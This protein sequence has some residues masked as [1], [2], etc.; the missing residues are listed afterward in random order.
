V[1]L[2]AIEE[3]FDDAIPSRSKLLNDLAFLVSSNRLVEDQ[4]TGL[5][6]NTFRK[7]ALAGS[8]KAKDYRQAGHSK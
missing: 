4:G 3:F 7:P 6:T 8:A 1:A 2:N 5:L